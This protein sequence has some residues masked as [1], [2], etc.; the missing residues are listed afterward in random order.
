VRGVLVAF[1]IMASDG[2]AGAAGSSV[3]SMNCTPCHQPNGQGVPGAYPALKD[4]VGRYVRLPAGRAYLVHVVAFGM[5]GA[6][7]SQ[8][9]TY[10]GFMQPWSQLPDADI[11]EA[12]NHIPIDLNTALLPDMFAPFTSAEVHGLRAQ[13]LTFDQVRRERAA[14]MNALEGTAAPESM[15][16]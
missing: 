14:V 15:H 2:I 16:P 6:I 11:A 12:L 4:T 10:N 5:T 3:F 7:V 1:L 8:G 9:Q 13:R